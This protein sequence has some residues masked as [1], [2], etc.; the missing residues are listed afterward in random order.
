MKKIVF[1]ISMVSIIAGCGEYIPSKAY[2]IKTVDGEVITLYCA[3]ID[4]GRSKLTYVIENDC[5]LV[6]E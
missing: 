4:R 6:K 5:Q 2:K 3:T 1:I